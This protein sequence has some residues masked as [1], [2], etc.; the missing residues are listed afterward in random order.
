MIDHS[1]RYLLT[2]DANKPYA[3]TK[4]MMT[5]PNNQTITD[6]TDGQGYTQPLYSNAPEDVTIHL[7]NVNETLDIG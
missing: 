5:L 6:I 2:D 1:L 7:F 4:Y 3:Y